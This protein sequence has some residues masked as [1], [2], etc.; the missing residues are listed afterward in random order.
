ML[1]VAGTVEPKFESLRRL[2]ETEMNRGAEHGAQLCAYV[3]GD[4]V[5]DLWTT[6]SAGVP[7][8]PDALSN[9]FSSGKSLEAIALASLVGRGLLRYDAE[10]AHYWPE[11]GANGKSAITVADLMRH[12]AGLA[13]FDSSLKLESLH[14]ENLKNNSIGGLIAEHPPSFRKDGNRREYHA[15]TRGWIANELFRRICPEGR[16]IGEYVRDEVAMPLEADVHIGLEEDQLERVAPVQLIP[17]GRY[18]RH[19]M[20]PAFMGRKVKLSTLHLARNLLPVLTKSGAGTTRKKPLPFEEMSGPGD[21]GAVFNDARMRMGETPSANTH[22]SARGLAKVA[23]SMAAGGTLQGTQVLP[24]EAWQQMH[25]APVE[26]DMFTHTSF[27]Q[28]GVNLFK[29]RESSSH[30]DRSANLGRDGFWGWMGMGGSIFQW[31]P[32]LNIGFGFVPTALHGLD[33]VNERGKAFQAE[34]VR[35]LG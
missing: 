28:G 7:H 35:C 15:L 9:I 26:A 12:E 11:F 30:T 2:F 25:D 3:G 27:S 19:T 6:T 14:R 17:L 32:S 31:H 24:A 18:V 22:A 20:R 5:V 8:S 1:E 21:L 13:A 4:R 34:L 33:V 23:A 10:I 16:T 29:V